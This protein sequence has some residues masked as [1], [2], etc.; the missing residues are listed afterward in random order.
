MRRRS[1]S[2]TGSGS[3]Q[4]SGLAC[5]ARVGE[6]SMKRGWATTLWSGIGQVNSNGEPLGL[7]VYSK[8]SSP[9]STESETV[10]LRKGLSVW[11]R[12]LS[13]VAR[14]LAHHCLPM[15]HIFY[16]TSFRENRYR[17]T[18]YCSSSGWRLKI[19]IWRVTIM[20]RVL[21]RSLLHSISSI[22]QKRPF[23]V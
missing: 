8:R 16:T 15:R 5:V 10:S 11:E 1:A 6:R 13:V 7:Y 12:P 18:L 19:L 3:S 21:Q 17:T 22:H 2:G 20:M 23:Q 14:L 4:E 9:W